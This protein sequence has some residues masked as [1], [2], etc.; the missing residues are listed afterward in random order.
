MTK[1]HKIKVLD[2]IYDYVVTGERFRRGAV[3]TAAE[4]QRF[5]ETELAIIRGVFYDAFDLPD[6]DDPAIPKLRDA[7]LSRA[8]RRFSAH[9]RPYGFRVAPIDEPDTVPIDHGPANSRAA[10]YRPLPFEAGL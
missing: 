6:D 10:L 1:R 5:L 2:D 8:V 9:A 7:L 4:A 3:M